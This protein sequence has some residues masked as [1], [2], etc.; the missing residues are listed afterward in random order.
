MIF[1]FT[2][3]AIGSAWYVVAAAAIA[4][5]AMIAGA[6][7]SI[8]SGYQAN[9]AA[10]E[11]ARMQE[12][13]SE[14][15]A[16][17]Q[18]MAA[19]AQQQQL[20]DQAELAN[21]QAGI[22][23]KKAAQA[24]EQGEMEAA[25]RSRLLAYDIGNAYAQWAGNGLLVDTSNDS[26]GELL[27]NNA[28]EAGQDIGIIK[29]NTANAV[30]EHEMNRTSALMSAASYRNQAANA[31]LIGEANAGATLLSG[32]AQA[33]A[34]RQAGL[35]ALYQGWGSGI[36]MFGSWAGGVVSAGGLGKMAGGVGGGAG[37][38]VGRTGGS[39]YGVNYGAY[40]NAAA[41]GF[42]LRP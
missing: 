5:V 23:Q 12:S 11:S 36:S 26:L 14:A 19:Q 24:Q 27:T 18:R 21:L 32:Q 10:R 6:G 33:Y 22:E 35:T 17:A 31:G 4:D 15:A 39:V 25:R 28:R 9:S 8:Y 29:T 38:T 41:L 40:D 37:G 7:M 30:W 42:G 20:N 16:N 3:L 2:A 13:A 34:T 1:C